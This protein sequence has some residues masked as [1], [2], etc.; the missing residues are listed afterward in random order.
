MRSYGDQCVERTDARGP[1]QRRDQRL[2]ASASSSSSS[3]EVVAQRVREEVRADALPVEVALEDRAEARA[4]RGRVA[5]E[6]SVG[7]ASDRG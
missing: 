6:A 3:S 5:A 1:V 2:P 7:A 4:S